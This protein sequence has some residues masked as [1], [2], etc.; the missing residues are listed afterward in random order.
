[1]SNII[2]EWTNTLGK[3]EA[4]ALRE[5]AKSLKIAGLSGSMCNWF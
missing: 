4:D 1:M 3:Y 5:L 2:N